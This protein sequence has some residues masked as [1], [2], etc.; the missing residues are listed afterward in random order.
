MTRRSISVLTL[1]MTAATAATFAYAPMSAA[2]STSHS[3]D[4]ATNAATNTASS[5]APAWLETATMNADAVKSGVLDAPKSEVRP[6]YQRRAYGRL[7]TNDL[8]GDGK[9]RWQTGSYSASYGLARGDLT[10]GIPDRFGE[11][12]EL[13]VDAA[14]MAPRFLR[15][16]EKGDRP[17]TGLM[18]FGLGTQFLMGGFEADLQST[19][20]F[21]GPETGLVDLQTGIHDQIDTA[22]RPSQQ[23]RD[24]QLN[25][26]PRLGAKAEIAKTF[27]IGRT[28]LR[29]FVEFESGM[30]T[31]SRAGFDFTI[32]S[33]GQGGILARDLVTG[34]R[35]QVLPGEGQ[36]FS[37]VMGADATAIH[38][39]DLL[40][41]KDG[42]TAL[43][44]RNRVRA[45]LHYQT[46]GRNLFYGMTYLSPETKIQDG[47]GQVAGSLRLDWSF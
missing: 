40:R 14:L 23:V 27:A 12:V 3:T 13:R 43:D 16:P 10:N 35:Y 44:T 7:V 30:E 42:V 34:Q 11:L 8:I 22:V 26:D 47:E 38:H 19:L 28:S 20:T 21:V 1:G 39:T 5:N 18:R 32:G 33:F 31:T 29:P 36:G 17:L 45:G 41:E 15:F 4:T 37:F 6:G 46:G 9:D 24:N 2:Q 25:L